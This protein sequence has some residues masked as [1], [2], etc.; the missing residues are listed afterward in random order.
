MLPARNL[1]LFAVLSVVFAGFGRAVR[2]VTTSGAITGAIV[3]FALLLATGFGGFAALLTVFLV[4]WA[5]T[6][7][8]YVKKQ[9]LGTAEAQSGRNASQV[10]A[11]LGTA[12]LCAIGLVVLPNQRWLV[13]IAAALAEAAADTV[14]SEI[15]QAIGGEPRLVTSWKRVAPGTN[16]AVTLFGSLAGAMAAAAVALVCYGTALF[17]S[18]S[19]LVCAMAGI[20]GMVA[21][22]FFGATVERRELLGNNG[23]N[24]ISTAIAAAVALVI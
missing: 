18:R 10:A 19:A 1:L 2:G 16:G 24:F 14:S 23:V 12:A 20:S 9:R 5:S 21:D 3:C 7:F 4:T 8:G 15:G 11:N 17:G 6:R 22:S 13:A